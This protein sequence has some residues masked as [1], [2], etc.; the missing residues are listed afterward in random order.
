MSSKPSTY[1]RIARFYDVDMAQNMR[2][3]DVAF[4]AHQCAR[5]RGRVLE[6]GCGNG[7]IL[8]P[9]LREGHDAFGVD[10]SGPML[11]ELA[12]KASAARLPLR[13]AQADARLL[14]FARATLACVLCPYSLV[15]YLAADVDLAAFL[16][17]VRDTLHPGGTVV[18]DAFVPRPVQAQSGFTQD[19]R[20]SFGAFTLARAKR[21]TPLGD[22][23]NRIERRYE[24]VSAAGDVVETVEVAEAIR[25][26]PPAALHAAMAGA[27][28]QRIQEA[29]DYGTRPSAEGAQ[30]VT[31]SGRAP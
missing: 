6:V 25:P 17:G 31:L 27:G 4:Y 2:F 22:G 14:P 23:T 24:V 3:D 10:A 26:R 16:R 1:D 8:L 13:A 11:H 19:Y 5:Q 28:F 30:F 21:I 9:L 7:R 18:V 15:T 20:R 29:W 12:R